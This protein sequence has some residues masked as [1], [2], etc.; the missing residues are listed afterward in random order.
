M[1]KKIE[2]HNIECGDILYH[3]L[4][5]KVSVIKVTEHKRGKNEKLKKI[6]M[7]KVRFQDNTEMYHIMEFFPD[8]LRIKD[9]KK[10]VL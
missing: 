10:E 4:G 9:T 3:V 6:T 7:V 2:G 8:E 5:Q 1:I